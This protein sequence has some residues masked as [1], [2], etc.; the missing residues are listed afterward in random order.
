MET[1]LELFNN[2]KKLHD[3]FEVND[4]SENENMTQIQTIMMA[5]VDLI[6]SKGF[7]TTRNITEKQTR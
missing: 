6:K 7:H 3:N 2:R 4:L 5:S 1:L